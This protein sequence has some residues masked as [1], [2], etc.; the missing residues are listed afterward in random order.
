MPKK[1]FLEAKCDYSQFYLVAFAKTYFF[2]MVLICQKYCVKASCVNGCMGMFNTLQYTHGTLPT[3]HQWHTFTTPCSTCIDTTKLHQIR[4]AEA[5]ATPRSV[6]TRGHFVGTWSGTSAFVFTR[7]TDA[8]GIVRELVNALGHWKNSA[9]D[10]TLKTDVI[11]SCFMTHE[12]KA[13]ESHATRRGDK[14]LSLQQTFFAKTGH[15]TREK[16]SSLQ[17]IPA[18]FLPV[19]TDLWHSLMKL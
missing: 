19:C 5:L 1:F 17:H 12:F 11:F 14:I 13:T 16:L 4:V 18:V 3:S 10:T 8:T 15:I 2:Y 6:Y 9:Q 7:K